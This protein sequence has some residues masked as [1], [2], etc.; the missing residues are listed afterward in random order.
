MPTWAIIAILV[1]LLIA[2][3]LYEHHKA[4]VAAAKAKASGKTGN[5]LVKLAEEIPVYGTAVK[6]AAVVEKPVIKAFNAV[7]N[8]V[9]AGIQHIPVAGKYLALPTKAAGK[10]VNGVMNFLGF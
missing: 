5:A 7:N 3:L 4:A 10:V 2:F 8:T 1:G 9:T 6:A